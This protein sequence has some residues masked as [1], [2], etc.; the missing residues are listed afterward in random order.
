[1]SVE[2]AYCS[3]PNLA[4]CVTGKADCAREGAAY[5]EI[6]L[7]GCEPHML[8]YHDADSGALLQLVFED[9]G[10]VG[11]DGLR[12]PFGCFGL[13]LRCAVADAGE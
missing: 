11:G 10:C 12:G 4:S 9:G 8:A 5:R 13:G 2:E 1:L 3:D 7:D 6:E